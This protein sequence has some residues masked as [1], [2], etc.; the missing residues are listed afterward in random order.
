MSYPHTVNFNHPEILRTCMSHLIIPQ[1]IIN[2]FKHR[3]ITWFA[4]KGPEFSV[5]EKCQENFMDY[6]LKIMMIK[7]TDKN[8]D[9]LEA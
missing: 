5:E 6:K 9:Y 1:F 7:L 3:P 8:K 4:Y 2:D